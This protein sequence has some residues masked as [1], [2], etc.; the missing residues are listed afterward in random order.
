MSCIAENKEKYITFSK[1]IL[2]DVMGEE[3]VYVK[4]KFLDTFKFM[5]KSLEELV[6][7][8]TKFEHTDKYFTPEQQELLRRKEVYPYDYMTDFSKLAETEPPP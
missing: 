4:L 1:S 3:N 6:R 7:T 5:D 8:T 2:A